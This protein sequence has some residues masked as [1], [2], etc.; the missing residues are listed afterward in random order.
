[1]QSNSTFTLSLDKA[2]V[3]L[4]YVSIMNA[5]TRMNEEQ[6]FHL[7]ERKLA[8]LTVID[9]AGESGWFTS[10]ELDAALENSSLRPEFVRRLDKALDS[11]ADEMKSRRWPLAAQV[12]SRLF[13]AYL[14]LDVDALA[15]RR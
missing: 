14:K 13:D 8:A 3:R 9:A 11:Y 6:D 2:P 7:D 1:M 5:L 15:V 12:L 4:H 10:A